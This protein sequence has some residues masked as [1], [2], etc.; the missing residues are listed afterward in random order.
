MAAEAFGTADMAIMG[1]IALSALFGVLRGFVREVVSLAIWLAAVV[2]GIALGHT[3]GGMI[4]ADAGPRMT[5]A[6]G[7][8]VVFIVV[9]VAGAILQRVLR[10]LVESTGLSGTDRVIGLLFGA[11]RGV[12][13]MIVAL[14]VLRP[15]AEE[16]QWWAEARLIPPLLSLEADLLGLV[17]Y[18]FDV[19]GTVDVESVQPDEGVF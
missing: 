5:M 9:L 17:N 2:L 14:V 4:L 16:R 18:V 6:I 11:A 1:V 3:V 15:F 13:V 12:A 8:A 10:G 19:G 7:F